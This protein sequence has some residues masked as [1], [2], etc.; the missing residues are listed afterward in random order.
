[1]TNNKNI[2]I[3]VSNLNE[4]P[5]GGTSL[6]TLISV[7]YAPNLGMEILLSSLN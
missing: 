2:R 6:D 4:I 3:D 7:D 1:V 5:I